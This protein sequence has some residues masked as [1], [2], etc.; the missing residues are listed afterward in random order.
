M[1]ATLQVSASACGKIA[2]LALDGELTAQTA[3]ELAAYA[4]G[5]GSGVATDVVLD[6]QRLYLLDEQGLAAVQEFAAGLARA[7]HCLA[8]AALRPRT[9]AFLQYVDAQAL[10]PM[11]ATVEEAADHLALARTAGA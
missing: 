7:G 4:A 1:T 10:A 6:L 3:G 8:L 11:Y 5:G 9:R 2:V